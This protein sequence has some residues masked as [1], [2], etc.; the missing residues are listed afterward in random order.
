MKSIKLRIT[1]TYNFVK[2]GDCESCA[3]FDYCN[4]IDD[5]ECEGGTAGH[6]ECENEEVEQINDL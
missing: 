5:T 6:Y 2:N 3:L 1:Q 4:E